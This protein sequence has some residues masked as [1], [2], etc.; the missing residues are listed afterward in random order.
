MFNRYYIYVQPASVN[1]DFFTKLIFSHFY[2]LYSDTD[3]VTEGVYHVE[4]YD[5]LFGEVF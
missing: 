4:I 3:K 2:H 5:I 1:T